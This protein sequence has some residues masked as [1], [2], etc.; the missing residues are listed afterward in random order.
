MTVF[1][2]IKNN[3]KNYIYYFNKFIDKF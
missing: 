2:L 1:N 3:L